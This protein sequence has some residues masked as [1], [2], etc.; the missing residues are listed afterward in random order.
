MKLE[1][2]SGYTV[3]EGPVLLVIMDGVGKGKYEDGD[4]V[5]A[6]HT[7]TL[8]WLKE[9]A[10]ETEL[11]AH[12]KAVGLPSD[13]DMGNSEAGH[14][15]M[16]C[17]RVFA[18]GAKLVQDAIESNRLFE[19]D[20]WQRLTQRVTE[21]DSVMHF[22]GLLSDGN[23][24]SHI[25]HLLAMLT[26]VA[27]DNVKKVRVHILLDGRDVG[28]TS[29]FEYVDQLE[30]YLADLNATGVD[31][32]IA[33]GG[34]RM[35]ITMDRYN[36][37]WSMVQRGWDT[38]VCGQGRGFETARQAIET[39]R[40]ENVGVG[41]QDLP[42]F[43]IVDG[44]TPVGTINDGDS[45]VLFNFRGDRAIELSRAFDETDI[46]QL[47]RDG[48]PDV[49]YAGMMQYDGDLDIPNNYLVNPPEISRTMGEYLATNGVKQ[50]AVSETQKFGHVTYFFNGNRSGKF[51]ETRETYIE[52]PSDVIP[53]EQRPWMKGAEVTD[54]LLDAIGKNEF[55]FIRVNFPHGDMVGHTG[56]FAATR[57][58][59]ETVDLCLA[60]LLPA[61]T[62]AGG[63]LIVTADH[64]NADD[65]YEHNKDGSVKV[66][67]DSGNINKKTSHSLNPVPC[68]IYDPAKK[69]GATLAGHEG[70]G[71]SS[72]AATCMNLK[73]DA[74]ALF[75]FATIRDHKWR[76]ICCVHRQHRPRT[77]NTL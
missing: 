68:Y 17:G 70:L 1:K 65:M 69:T 19:G 27:E 54:L 6:A 41:D 45:V 71:I 16:G 66:D 20:T 44:D 58:A 22:V 2:I 14:N 63:V 77:P 72:I 43:V 12:G 24:H 13:A 42:P 38:H 60:R 35:A 56:D 75:S 76:L 55:D 52:V 9:H 34:G 28:A 11:F 46:S 4:A 61:L 49:L 59:V 37:D 32:R 33:S 57:I 31:Y 7:P 53:F 39:Y 8:D 64:G 36:A 30:T 67:P 5:A 48:V 15:A 29:A 50:L 18:Q 47:T 26:K 40:D 3:P 23:V 21:N 73:D 74:I 62:Q 10:L 25:N 51:D